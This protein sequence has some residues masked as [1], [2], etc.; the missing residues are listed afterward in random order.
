MK[1]MFGMKGIYCSNEGEKEY[2]QNIGVGTFREMKKGTSILTLSHS[3]MDARTQ[4][5]VQFWH[6]QC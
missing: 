6:Y 5:H 4:G 1:L 2:V 3:E